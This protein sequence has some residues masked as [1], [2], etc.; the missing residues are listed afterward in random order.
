MVCYFLQQV[1]DTEMNIGN[2]MMTYK[3]LKYVALMRWLH[4]KQRLEEWQKDYGNWKSH[5]EVLLESV[6]M[7][8]NNWPKY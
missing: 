8:Q 4:G 3:N 2:E 6:K 5:E 7:A 1:T